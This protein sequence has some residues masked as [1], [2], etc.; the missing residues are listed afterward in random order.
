MDGFFLRGGSTQGNG[1][2]PAGS[3]VIGLKLSNVPTGYHMIRLR[4]LVSG[5][6][7]AMLPVTQSIHNNANLL[8]Q[9][10]SS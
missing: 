2:A 4:W 9:E 8:V 5:G 7:L 1:G 3:A 10:V 6:V